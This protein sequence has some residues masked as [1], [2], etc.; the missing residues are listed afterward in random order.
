MRVRSGDSSCR[1]RKETS[2]ELSKLDS[3]I[4]Q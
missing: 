4:G 1:S 3:R 2:Q